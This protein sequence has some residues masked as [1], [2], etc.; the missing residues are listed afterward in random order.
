MLLNF[1]RQ[2]AVSQ[3]KATA[4]STEPPYLKKNGESPSGAMRQTN[5]NGI[6][7]N[8]SSA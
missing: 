4:H 1:G 6:V 8:K 2:A 5:P 3:Y 7:I